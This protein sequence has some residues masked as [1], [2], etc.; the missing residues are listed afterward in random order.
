MAINNLT[1]VKVFTY[2][3]EPRKKK[4]PYSNL[5]RGNTEKTLANTKAPP[6]LGQNFFGHRYKVMLILGLMGLKV[7][8]CE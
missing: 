2:Q 1:R 5:Y 4:V 6:S 8:A 3:G 7:R